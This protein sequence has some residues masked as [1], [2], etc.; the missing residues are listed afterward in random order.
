MNRVWT[1]NS[2]SELFYKKAFLKTFEKFVGKHLYRSLFFY[3]SSC[4]RSVWKHDGS[5]AFEVLF[6]NVFLEVIS[7]SS[8]CGLRIWLSNTFRNFCGITMLRIFWPAT[9]FHRLF[10]QSQYVSSP[11]NKGP[12][13]SDGTWSFPKPRLTVLKSNQL[14]NPFIHNIEK[15]RNLF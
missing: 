3:Q 4:Q 12:Q 1:R 14:V 6:K 8:S 9:R 2:H 10:F 7:F 5:T 15:C 13:I 11:S